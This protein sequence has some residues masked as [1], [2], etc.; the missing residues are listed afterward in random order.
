MVLTPFGTNVYSGGKLR[1]DATLKSDFC[2]SETQLEK[3]Q[4]NQ[5]KNY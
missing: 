1:K 2:G 5:Q 3:V 4:D